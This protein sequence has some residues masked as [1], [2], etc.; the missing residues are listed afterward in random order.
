M[1]TFL[2]ALSGLAWTIV[3]I[4]S[5]RIGFKHKTYAIPMA[6]LALNVSWEWLYAAHD[7]TGGGSMQGYINLAWAAADL[8][9]VYTYLRFGRTEL[10]AF[11]TRSMFGAWSVAVF[12]AAGIVEWIFIAQFDWHDAARNSAFLQNLLMSGLFVAML[13]ARAS[14][15]GQSMII[16]VGKWVGTLAPTFVFGVYEQS[17]FILTLGVLCSVFDLAYIGLLGWVRTHPNAL[18]AASISPGMTGA[19]PPVVHPD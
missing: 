6:A 5:I 8:L 17:S 9:I 18:Q 10:P 14:S 16:A 3:Y 15:R 13:V 7:L 11:V 12:A 4:E 19:E 1:I 2:T